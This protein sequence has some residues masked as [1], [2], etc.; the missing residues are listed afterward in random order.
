M[1]YDLQCKETVFNSESFLTI[2]KTSDNADELQAVKEKV[3]L[4][5]AR[6]RSRDTGDDDGMSSLSTAFSFSSVGR[7]FPQLLHVRPSPH[8]NISGIAAAGLLQTRC[9]CC[10]PTVSSSI[11][12]W[13][14][15]PPHLKNSNV[16]HEQFKSALKT[17]LFMQAYS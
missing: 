8:G 2:L 7:A 15:L 12:I 6:L 14:M 5:I 4:E 16:S 11:Q 10:H 9:P 1:V 17:W 13:N 3:D